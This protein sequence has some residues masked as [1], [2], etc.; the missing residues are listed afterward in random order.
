MG[1][2]ATGNPQHRSAC[3]VP[4]SVRRRLDG[5]TGGAGRWSAIRLA[6]GNWLHC[7]ACILR[8]SA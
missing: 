7:M 5:A 8:R 1:I 4:E 3:R 2:Q 6:S